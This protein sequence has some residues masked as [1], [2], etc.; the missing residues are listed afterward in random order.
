MSSAHRKVILRQFSGELL[1]GYL[2]GASFVTSGNL[3]LLGLDGRRIASPLES[4]KAVFFVRDFNL[5]DPLSPE[6]LIR[7]TFLA[8]P[9]G[10]GLWIRLTFRQDGDQLEGLAP[11]DLTLCD[12]LA[13]NNGVQFSPPDVRSNTQRVFVPRSSI[14]DL[15]ILAVITS[16]SRRQAAPTL[17]RVEAAD[18]SPQASL[19]PRRPLAIASGDPE[20]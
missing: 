10:D 1:Q 2:S 17:P 8:R 3:D 11:S 9:R 15:R 19:F 16:P 20:Q 18:S 4:L 7:K 13:L 12:D 14:A 6:R 5:G